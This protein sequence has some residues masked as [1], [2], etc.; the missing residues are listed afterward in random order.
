MSARRPTVRHTCRLYQNIRSLGSHPAGDLV[1]TPVVGCH[2]TFH[3]ARGYLHS[4]RARAPLALNRYQIILLGD[5][6]TQV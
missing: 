5:R 3:H 4:R 6:G 2:Y 1:I